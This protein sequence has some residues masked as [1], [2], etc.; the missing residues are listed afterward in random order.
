MSFMRFFP[1][2]RYGHWLTP[3]RARANCV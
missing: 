1:A 3:G 2:D